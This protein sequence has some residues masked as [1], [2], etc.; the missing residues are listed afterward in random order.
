MC[1]RRNRTTQMALSREQK[2]K[3]TEDLTQNFGHQKSMAFVDFQGLKVKDMAGLR[4]KIKEVGGKLQVAKK[5]LIKL[6][7]EKAGFKLEK[8]LE[9]E[10]RQN[11]DV[12][13][14]SGQVGLIFAFEDPIS[15]LKTAYQFS[16]TNENLKILAGI[17][18]GKLIEK[19][20][21]LA[22]AQLSSREELLARLVGSISSPISGFV[23]VLQ[24]N[25]RG[26][27]F[28]LSAIKK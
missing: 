23:N 25:I 4:K 10:T 24:G 2:Q 21:V 18:E 22:L 5:T 12:Q 6:A 27:V 7:L 28:V 20:K 14:L 16:Q 11:F 1:G 3:I 9:G 8:E 13:S 17:F 19:D 26:L 15:P